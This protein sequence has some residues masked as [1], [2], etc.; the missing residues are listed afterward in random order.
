MSTPKAKTIEAFLRGAIG[1]TI[2]LIPIKYFFNS[3]PL[4]IFFAG[5][6]GIIGERFVPFNYI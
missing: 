2:G 5:I 1:V 3:I 4:I 6:T